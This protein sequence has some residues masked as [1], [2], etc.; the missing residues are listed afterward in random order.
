MCAR[1]MQ[2]M[3][4]DVHGRKPMLLLSFVSGMLQYAVIWLLPAGRVCL[5]AGLCV[6]DSFWLL[7]PISG[8]ISC[9]GG[10]NVGELKCTELRS[11]LQ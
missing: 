10:W 2:A 3:M 4:A 11:P 7:L 9:F 1:P 5:S 6:E 8:V